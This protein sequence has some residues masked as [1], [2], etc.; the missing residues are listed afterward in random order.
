MKDK[1]L[2]YIIASAVLVVVLICAFVFIHMPIAQKL[3]S[4]KAEYAQK[5]SQLELVRKKVK[6]LTKLKDDLQKLQEEK[7]TLDEK[8]PKEIGVPDMV[9][10]LEKIAQDSGVIVSSVEFK[11]EQETSPNVPNIMV[12]TCSLKI[13]GNYYNIIKYFDFIKKAPRLIGVKTISL[14]PANEDGKELNV[15]FDMCYFN[16]ANETATQPV[17][18]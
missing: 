2:P 18:K 12:N 17:T 5:K 4:K 15:S 7:M 13:A 9:N 1:R 6:E 3:Q 16:Y 11:G 8:I 14:S 10:I